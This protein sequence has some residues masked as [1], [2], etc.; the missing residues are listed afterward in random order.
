ME[1]SVLDNNES[2]QNSVH[3]IAHGNCQNI[4]FAEKIL[5]WPI[6]AQGN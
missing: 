5:F 4:E 2:E 6:K 3:K 1:I